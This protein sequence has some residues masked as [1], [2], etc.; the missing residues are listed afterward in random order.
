MSFFIL[1]ETTLFYHTIRHSDK[2]TNATGTTITNWHSIVAQEANPPR[3][4]DGRAGTTGSLRTA[5]Q[6]NVVFA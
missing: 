5:H 1:D 6:E 3:A 2:F 4:K